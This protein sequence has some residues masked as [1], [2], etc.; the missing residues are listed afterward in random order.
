MNAL[1]IDSAGPA[2][3]VAAKNNLQTVTV[4]LNIGPKQS[5]EILPAID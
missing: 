4:E 3:K 5:Q 2:M 1:A